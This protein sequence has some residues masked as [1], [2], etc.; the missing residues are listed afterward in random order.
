MKRYAR[1][2]L[3]LAAVLTLLPACGTRNQTAAPQTAVVEYGN[4]EATVSTSGSL[5][6]RSQV[7]LAFQTS[8]Q[9]KA[10]N[11][12]VGDRVKAGQVLA[13]LDTPDLDISLERAQASLDIARAQLE[14]TRQGAR[15]AQV[16]A[17]RASLASAQAAYRAALAKMPYQA[18]SVNNAK[19]AL[20]DAKEALDNAQGDYDNL[21]RYDN[22]IGRLVPEFSSRKTALDNAKVEYNT[23]LANYN[24]AVA[25][26]NNSTLQSAQQ[27]VA[28]AQAQLDKLLNTPTAHDLALAELAVKQ[29]ELAV[30]QA[31]NALA[32]AVIAAP[33]DGVVASVSIQPGLKASA[34]AA[35]ISMVDLSQLHVEVIV[36]ETD[37]ARIKAG[38]AARVTFDALSGVAL[39]AH[40]ASAAPAGTV[41]QGVVNYSVHVVLDETNPALRPGMTA[42]AAI[43][44]D[45]RENV[46]L[47]PNRAIKSSGK[48]K[49]VTLLRDGRTVTTTVTLGLTGEAY[50]EVLS[51]L[52][53]GEAVVIPG[54]T[55]TQRMGPGGMAG[56]GPPPGEFIRGD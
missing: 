32:R 21:I 31:K 30:Q 53:A 20:D 56:G 25:G 5:A 44:V 16:A 46:P 38:Q 22:T 1:I 36:A 55:T 26:L 29:A 40:V 51:G 34:N 13:Q 4:L 10:V 23:A 17:A 54:T 49:I 8:G 24:L 41:T 39:A 45:R 35:A 7:T 9:V 42:V 47:I 52:Q 28:Q 3:A 33:F 43:I 6:A 37:I 15:P 50:S 48:S 27:Q 2:A 12:Q 19:E 11:V 18:D 14:Q